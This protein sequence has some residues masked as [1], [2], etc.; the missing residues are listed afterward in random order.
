[1]MTFR[2]APLL[3]GV[4]AGIPLLVPAGSASAFDRGED[5]V[6]LKQLGKSI[7]NDDISVPG[8]KQGC[9]SCHELAKG[10]V[11]P[12]STINLTTVV[13]PG[14]APHAVGNIK[15]PSNTYATYSPPFTQDDGAPTGFIGGN[16]WDG[17]AEGYGA[18]AALGV[19]V[20][21]G[22]TSETVTV[23]DIPVPFQ[24]EYSKYLGPTADQALNPFPNSVEQNVRKKKVC[25]SVKTAKYKAEYFAAYGESIDCSK[26]LDTSYNRIAL[27]L[28]AYQDSTEANKFTSARDK[29]YRGETNTYEQEGHDLFYGKAACSACHNGVPTR[30]VGG[31]QDVLGQPA[32]GEEPHQLFTD[33][34]FHHIG[35]PYN[36]EIPGVKIGEKVGLADHQTVSVINV[37]VLDGLPLKGFFRTPTLRNVDKGVTDTFKKAYF[38]NG[39]CKDLECV[40]HFYNT[41]DVLD[42]CESRGI[43][44]AT[45]AEAKANNCWPEPEFSASAPGNRQAQ[46]PVGVAGTIVLVGNLGLTPREEAALVTFLKTLS[47]Q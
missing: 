40:V 18:P 29:F 38:H 42:S 46:D 11:L 27:A 45:A 44:S 10:G 23:A 43:T 26:G 6:A 15:P 5:A 22:S 32:P 35:V 14:A 9:H 30:P 3:V 41:R 7:F 8:N 2:F 1:M 24:T 39:W 28:A 25:Q 47:D 12:D 16:F 13:A 17:R 33:N 34:R 4:L 31:T 36:R 19:P 37:P 20:G 21:D